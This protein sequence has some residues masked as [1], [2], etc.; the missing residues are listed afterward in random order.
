MEAEGDEIGAYREY[1][2]ACEGEYK[3][4]EAETRLAKLALRMPPETLAMLQP[5]K[6]SAVENELPP[7]AAERLQ[8]E[9]RP[10]L[11][12]I[13]LSASLKPRRHASAP[14][15]ASLLLPGFGQLLKEEYVKAAVMFVI[16]MV[17][18]V[19]IFSLAHTSTKLNPAYNDPTVWAAVVI[20]VLDYLVSIVDA[21]S[22][23]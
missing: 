21:R 9:A 2:K 12:S 4:T 10:V 16:W 1:Q 7:E 3:P 19:W 18:I 14:S 15:F 8:K 23:S 20:I 5:Q 13:E 17:A 22:S 11:T 6:R